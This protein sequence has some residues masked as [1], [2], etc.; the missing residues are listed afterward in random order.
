M[1]ARENIKRLLT[2]YIDDEI[3]AEERVEV[4]A[5]IKKNPELAQAM[6]SERKLKGVLKEQLK[7]VKAPTHL[8]QRIRRD[9]LRADE[10]PSFT[11][12]VSS[13]FE[14][15]PVATSLAFAVLALLV[16]VPSYEVVTSRAPGLLQLSDGA[17]NTYATEGTLEGEIICLDCEVFSAGRAEHN[18]QL[19]RPGLRATD[20]TIWTIVQKR[21]ED[22]QRYG[23]DLL[24]KKA[25][26]TGIIFK[27]SRYISVEG[28]QLL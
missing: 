20:G 28:Y 21:S 16:F 14:Y 26:L 1:K 17:G 7:G 18:V 13:F 25:R 23:R 27:N 9:I 4:E 5:A 2:G 15:R 11:E 10:K 22:K 12:L 8:R 19:H 6:E 3:S 24:K